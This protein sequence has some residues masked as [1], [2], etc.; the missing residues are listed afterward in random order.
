[1]SMTHSGIH[2][3]TGT[4]INNYL[5]TGEQYDPNIGFYYLRARYYNQGIGRFISSDPAQDTPYD[6]ISLHKYLYVSNN[7]VNDYDPSGRFSLMEQMTTLAVI[8]A[9]TESMV[10]MAVQAVA[11]ASIIRLYDYAF[12]LKYEGI[13]LLSSEDAGL[14]LL[15]WS[16]I[17]RAH[18]IIEWTQKWQAKSDEAIAVYQGLELVRSGLTALA[19]RSLNGPP[20]ILAK[21]KESSDKA[22]KLTAEIQRS[23]GR[24]ILKIENEV[25]AFAVGIE[26]VGS[27]LLQIAPFITDIYG[28]ILG[29]F[30]D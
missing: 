16:M 18:A 29:I 2:Q 11:A 13:R 7:P 26:E 20:Q 30:G 15:G 14:S 25:A 17:R 22:A 12:A 8:S 6:P 9:L 21:L 4:T 10:P 27:S 5:Y 24:H 3:R 28:R 1:M 23:L 19:G